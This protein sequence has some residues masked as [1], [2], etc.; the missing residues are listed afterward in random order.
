VKFAARGFSCALAALLLSACSSGGPAPP[1]ES[2][3][4][5]RGYQQL[6]RPRQG[7]RRSTFRP[8]FQRILAGMLV[9]TGDRHRTSLYDETG[10]DVVLHQW[11]RDHGAPVNAQAI[12]LTRDWQDDWV[13]QADLQRMAD[14]GV[15]PVLMLY[16]FGGDISRSYVMEHR[17]EWY[18]YLMR[19][20]SLAAI[21]AP[22]LVVLEPEFNDETNH[23][24]TLV[25]DWPG[26]NEI[27]IDG[28]YLLRSMAPNLLVG[29][30]AGDFGEQDLEPSIGEVAAYA[31]FLAYQEMRAS[32]RPSAM[33]EGSEDV[34][35][36]SL[37]YADYLWRTFGKPVLLA[38]VAVSTYDP[39][40][41]RWEQHQ[42]DVVTHLFEQRE[43]L[44]ERGVFGLLYF[45]LFDDPQHVGYFDD[46]ERYFGLFTADGSPK[47]GWYAF[48]KGL[49][50]MAEG[51]V[52]L[53]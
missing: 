23:G 20:A 26:F 33:R 16:W 15:V 28:I 2:C 1:P 44:A 45:M 5:Q 7:A 47:P 39:Q 6:P 51:L 36:R 12:W 49:R 30:C 27:V 21:N 43:A 42:A 40:Q 37:R 29:I 3:Y 53:R 4:L 32:T 22:V 38:Y 19:V 41:Q 14:D 9:G 17:H 35:D 24:G 25:L 34:T 46:A 31:D 10:R 52:K 48:Q 50:E 8:A 11:A 13:S 18:V